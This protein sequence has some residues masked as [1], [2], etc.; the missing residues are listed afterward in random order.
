M[1][2]RAQTAGASPRPTQL[3]PV[4]V[5]GRG[6][7]L[8]GV[9]TSASQGIVGASELDARP[10]LRRGELLEVI[11][12]VAITQHSGNGK[13]N[14]YFLRG[15]NLDHGTDFALSVDGLPVNMRSHAH[16]QGYADLNFLIPEAIQQVDYNKGPFYAEVGD[17]SAAGAA[18]F[19][20]VDTFARPFVSLSVGENYFA[21]F[22]AGGSRR[23]SAG[24]LTGALEMSQDDGPWLLEENAERFNGFVRQHW[25]NGA[26]DFRLTAMAYHGQWRSTD[27][28]P[29]RAVEAG[30]LE[31]F[32]HVDPTDGG[33]SD[34][35]SLSFDATFKGVTA[36]TR[37]NAYALFY[38][39]NLY[40]NFTYFLDDPLN[41]DQFNQRDRRWVAGG[42][43]Q[44]TWS[45]GG[46]GARSETTVGLQGRADFVGELGLH[47]ARHR[48]RVGTVRDD[49]VDEASVGAF[50]RNETPWT[51]WLRTTAGLRI[52][53]YRF[54]VSSSEPR[55]S[56]SE[57]A[58][59]LSPKLSVALGPWK[60]TE[61]YANVGYGFH[62][63]DARGTTI[64][65]DPIDGATPADAVTPLARSQGAEVGLRVAPLPGLVSTVSVWGLDLDSEL[66]FVGDAGGTEPSGRT[67]RYGI[68]LA[69][70]YRIT[71]WCAVDADIAFTGA[72]YRDDLGAGTR[73]ANSIAS[74]VT[75]GVAL[76]GNEGWFGSARMRYYGPQPLIED[77]SVR[78]PSSITYNARLGW[79]SRDWEL[80]LEALNL[81]DRENYDI[82]YSYTSRLP[83]EPAEGFDDVH[84]HPAEPLTFR[85]SATRRF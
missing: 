71:P 20:Q 14:Q 3:P 48:A 51:E 6:T 31:L 70:Y 9:A 15:F 82:A 11:P 16:G 40:S 80:A 1:P 23:Q 10:F 25:S 30:A 47:R 35:A 56:G 38:R 62:S 22:V 29:L 43:L 76:G 79:R 33:E 2:L 46:I 18:Q 21:R 65:V 53:G 68:E 54:E 13:A 75:A 19:R 7:D 8:V 27:Q 72:R 73:I 57:D 45:S 12:G 37:L 24:A 66:V 83:G 50:A 67:R 5:Q 69:N 44:R 74:V 32:G 28:I 81:F 84:F 36:T 60:K 34:R 85:L 59:L 4:V 78:A 77:N 26:G 58:A 64:R 52:D 49:E 63:N 61:V 55:N 42:E 17:F 41:G 39:L